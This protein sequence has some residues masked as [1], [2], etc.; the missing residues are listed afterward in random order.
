MY[1]SI[2]KRER[3]ILRYIIFIFF[4]NKIIT[5]RCFLRLKT[6]LVKLSSISGIAFSAAV[7]SITEQAR[8]KLSAAVT[9]RACSGIVC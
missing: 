5:S 8:S 3:D 1:I 4:W 9:N 2:E 6:A 7:F